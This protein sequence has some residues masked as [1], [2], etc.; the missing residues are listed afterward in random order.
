MTVWV[1]DQLFIVRPKQGNTDVLDGAWVDWQ[2]LKSSMAENIA[3]LLPDADFRPVG[4]DNLDPSVTLASLPARRRD[5]R[6]RLQA[7]G[8]RLTTLY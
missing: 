2:E 5:R 6:S 8:H 3:D 7:C 1:D 4:D